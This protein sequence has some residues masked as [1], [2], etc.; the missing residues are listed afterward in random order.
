MDGN[1]A[2]ILWIPSHPKNYE[3]GRRGHKIV[4]ATIHDMEAAERAHTAE[5]MASWFQNPTAR[6]GGAQYG[7]D[8]DS[9]VQCI[10]DGD[11]AYHAP[12]VSEDHIG[13]ELAGF[14]RQAAAEWHDPYSWAM[15]QRAAKL[16][17]AK[18]A[19]YD[20]PLVFLPA[21][22]LRQTK[23]GVT[24]HNEVRIA[25]GRTTHTDPGPGF[26]MA[27]FLT[28]A[29]AGA[30]T[31]APPPASAV[32]K[33]GSKGESVAFFGDMGNI[34]AQA[35]FALNKEGKPSRVHIVIPKSKA[36]RAKCTFNGALHAR[37][38]EIQRFANAMAKMAGDPPVPVTGEVDARTAGIVAYW[39]PKALAKLK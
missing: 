21:A 29:S 8:A 23:R 1:P 37:A 30:H 22:T 2:E 13:I 14:A 28:M 38:E 16:L 26:P 25:F 24:T 3:K 33:L 36:N 10:L 6:I 4:G 34:L 5:G 18:A 15:L 20:F 39:V 17:A 35:G 7:V 32:L 11:M 9:T 19:Q 12:G 27:E 31:V